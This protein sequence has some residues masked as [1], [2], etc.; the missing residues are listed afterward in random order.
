MERQVENRE[1]ILARQFL[2]ETDCHI[3]LTGKAGTGKTTFLHSLQKSL[4]KRMVI[5]APT[6]VAAINAGGVTIHS[7]FQRPLGPYLPGDITRERHNLRKEKVNMMR[8]LDLLV[9]DEISMV[10]ADLLDSI[11]AVLRRYRGNE[12]PFGGV[13]LLMIGDLYQLPPVVKDSDWQL[14][15]PHYTTPYFFSSLALRNSELLTI[16]LRHVFRQRDSRFITLLNKVRENRIEPADLTL[17]NSRCQLSAQ[18]QPATKPQETITLCSHNNLAESINQKRLAELDGRSRQY[19]AEVSGE[20]PESTWPTAETL[21]LKVGAQVMFVRND[22]STEKLFYNGKIGT[23]TWIE[24]ERVGVRCEEDR[25][26]ITV[27]GVNW[28][29]IEYSLNQET[30]ELDQNTIG[31]FKQLPLKLA[32]A[33]TIHKSQ[34]L[35]FDQVIIDA[36]AAFAHGQ[37]YVALSRCRSFEGLTLA[38][39]VSYQSIKTD[40]NIRKFSRYAAENPP[41]ESRLALARIRYQQKLLLQCFDFGRLGYRMRRFGNT[42]LGNASIVQLG[43]VGE[44][45]ELMQEIESQIVAV[46][47]NFRRQLGGL[48]NE[49]KIPAE[50]P[51]IMERITKGS[52]W[53]HQQFERLLF[54]MYTTLFFETDNT[55][56]RA[57]LR[58]LFKEM[59][60]EITI[61]H[62]AISSCSTE[63]STTGYLRAIG[64]AATK[65][66]TAPKGS[67]RE[68]SGPVYS[69]ADIAHP[70]FFTTLKK[71]RKEQAQKED[72][73]AYRVLAQKPLIQLAIHLPVTEKALLKIHGIGPKLTARYGEE[74]LAMI[75]AYRLAHNITEISLPEG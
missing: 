62:A 2:E 68:E 57:R 12:L 47:E 44:L 39:P 7:F 35:T 55:Q 14:L 29:N 42:L 11:D 67:S 26:E 48:F 49:E 41:T 37:T 13:Q 20:F 33:I 19:S 73:P 6:G 63:F 60:E 50:D 61:K 43:G 31:T 21:R 40:P 69:E 52:A 24:K 74:L 66:Q 23:I 27:E 22:S 5:T 28:E 71:W 38:S 16:E 51:V 4:P 30:L 75:K 53:F 18:D 25:G 70:D 56:I 1:Q 34:G 46:G 45:E 59:A 3:F 65:K 72:L 54:P 32:W 64:A 15:Q 36:K 8:N 10:R 58:R 17:L 9:I